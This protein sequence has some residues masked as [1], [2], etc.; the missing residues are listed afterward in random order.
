[1]R[2]LLAMAALA[3]CVALIPVSIADAGGRGGGGGGF[4]GGGHGGGAR[5]HMGGGGRGFHGGGGSHRMGPGKMGGGHGGMGPGKMGGGH[6]LGP[7]I[8]NTN[9]NQN[10]NQ[11]VNRNTNQNVN[12]NRNTNTNK[13]VNNNN[14]CTGSSCNATA[15]GGQ[16][17]AKAT[18]GS[19]GNITI[20]AGSNGGGGFAS[21][22]A[23]APMLMMGGFGG[24]V[25]PATPVYTEAYIPQVEDTYVEPRRRHHHKRAA[26]P[27][28]ATVTI[29][30]NG[31]GTSKVCE[32]PPRINK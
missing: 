14:A 2:K 23:V 15:Y 24:Q 11:N 6:N 3:A 28:C 9:F 31:D 32:A 10:T 4:R 21:A 7:G 5:M 20:D 29:D 30:D 27:R 8:R 12:Q 25:A 18:G 1:M 16:A 22:F 26:G 17:T 13:N 19:V